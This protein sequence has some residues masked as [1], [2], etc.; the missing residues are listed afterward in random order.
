M[1]TA[2][3]S[4]A[5]VVEVWL[6]SQFT[7]IIDSRV[8]RDRLFAVARHRQVG[9]GA[10]ECGGDDED[11]PSVRAPA[12]QVH[13]EGHGGERKQ[14][15]QVALP[16]ASLLRGEDADLGEQADRERPRRRARTRA[17]PAHAGE[18]ARRRR[19]ATMIAPVM[20]ASRYACSG[21]HVSVDTENEPRPNS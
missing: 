8:V 15:E 2:T 21:I 4:P 20:P 14:D 17:A 16:E 3:M 12:L 18:S 13:E 5:I 1:P 9:G 11:E 7:A 6:C 19:P 10:G